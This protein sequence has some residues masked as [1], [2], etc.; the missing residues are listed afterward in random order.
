[1]LAIVLFCALYRKGLFKNR[2]FQLSLVLPFIMSTPWLYWNYRIFGIASILE[3]DEL[4][5]VYKKF[6]TH[7]PLAAVLIAAVFLLFRVWRRSKTNIGHDEKIIHHHKDQKWSQIVSILVP[8]GFFVFCIPN[9]FLHSLQFTYV[10]T[11]SWAQGIFWNEPAVFYFG[12]LIEYSFI[13]VLSFYSVFMYRA[14]ENN[15]APFIRLSAMVILIFFIVWG[16]FQSRYILSSLPFLIILGVQFGT[17]LYEVSSESK[18]RLIYYTGR[19]GLAILFL[20]AVLKA[21]FLNAVVSYPNNMC[22]F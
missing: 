2:I 20:Y 10:P 8:V 17:H 18:I 4:K 22:Y 7:L 21:S 12:R 16:N 19:I 5:I 3:H 11:H 9:Q 1:M 15:E 14:E 13:Y 6:L